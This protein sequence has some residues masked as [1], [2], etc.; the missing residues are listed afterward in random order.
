M[1]K[2]KGEQMSD[3][4][5]DPLNPK[6][7]RQMSEESKNLSSLLFSLPHVRRELSDIYM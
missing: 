7:F 6:R 2:G 5:K 3:E 1:M 4:G